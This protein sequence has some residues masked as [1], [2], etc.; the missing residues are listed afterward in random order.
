MIHDCFVYEAKEL[1]LHG[2]GPRKL[3]CEGPDLWQVQRILFCAVLFIAQWAF[4]CSEASL[5]SKSTSHAFV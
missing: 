3:L 2:L 1:A 4:Q 5:H